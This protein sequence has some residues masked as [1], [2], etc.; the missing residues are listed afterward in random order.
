M[1]PT[2]THAHTQTPT[3]THRQY[4]ITTARLMMIFTRTQLCN[5]LTHLS[6]Q[7]AS[8]EELLHTHSHMR[9]RTHKHLP[10]H[11]I[12][13]TCLSSQ[14]ASPDDLRNTH[15]PMC[16][17]AHA[18]TPTHISARNTLLR[19]TFLTHTHTHKH[20][21]KHTNH[22]ARNTPHR[23][24]SASSRRSPSCARSSRRTCQWPSSAQAP[25]THQE[26]DA[27]TKGGAAAAAAAAAATL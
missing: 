14:H 4:R 8:P 12:T 23:K 27:V 10:T 22:S 20:T 11:T 6:S 3:P 1:P 25:S 2:H 24:T 21:H 5:P 15:T 7:H 9:A 26:L 18:Q 19:K 13:H 16:V 17:R